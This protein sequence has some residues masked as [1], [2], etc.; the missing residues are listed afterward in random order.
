MQ[1]DTVI[2]TGGYGFIGSALVK[3]LLKDNVNVINI[4][5]LTYAANPDSLDSIK[6]LKNYHFEKCD[7]CDSAQVE[8][9]LAK[10]RPNGVFHL[11]AESHVDNSIK[12]P[13]NFINTIS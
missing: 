6:H 9:I 4:D 11:A 5:K 13:N 1:I 7:I 2:V 10:Y 3:S 8:K 12:S